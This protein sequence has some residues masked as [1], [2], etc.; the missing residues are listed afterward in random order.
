[1]AVKAW[2]LCSVCSTREEAVAEMNRIAEAVA[3]SRVRER[4]FHH[5]GAE[6]REYVVEFVPLPYKG[7]I[8]ELQTDTK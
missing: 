3:D 5:G 8:V 6:V 4:V 2:R 7:G 1:M